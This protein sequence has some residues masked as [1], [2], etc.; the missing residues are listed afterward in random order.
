MLI[1]ASA[2]PE[3]ARYR[4]RSRSASRTEI[5]DRLPSMASAAR[6]NGASRITAAMSTT[7]PRASFGKPPLPSALLPDQP[8]RMNAT[9]SRTRPG[10][11]ERRTCLGGAGRPDRAVTIGTLVMALAGR[12]AANTAATTASS[13]ARPITPHGRANMPIRWCALC[14]SAGR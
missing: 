2:E 14:S 7:R 3:R 12:H 10:T 9:T 13:S 1:A 4:D 11:A 6:Q 8:N 5:G